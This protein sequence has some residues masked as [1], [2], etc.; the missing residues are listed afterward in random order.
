MPIKLTKEVYLKI[1]KMSQ[2]LQMPMTQCIN[3]LVNQW[4]KDNK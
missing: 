2:K 4:L 1:K 3:M